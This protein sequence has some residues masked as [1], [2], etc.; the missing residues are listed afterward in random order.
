[1]DD[2]IGCCSANSPVSGASKKLSV[3]VVSASKADVRLS[4]GHERH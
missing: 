3:A 1:M 2:L 4:R